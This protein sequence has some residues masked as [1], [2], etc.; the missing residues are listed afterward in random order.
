MKFKYLLLSLIFFISFAKAQ[1][2]ADFLINYPFPNCSPAVISFVNQ[3]TGAGLLSYEWNFGI[4]AGINSTQLNPSTTFIACGTYNVSLKTTNSSGQVSTTNKQVVINC[5]PKAN[6]SVISTTGCSPITVN[7][8]SVLCNPGNA[9]ITSYQW[10]F[11]DGFGSTSANPTHVYTGSGCKSVTLI[12]TNS[13]GCSDDTTITDIVC[14][15]PAPVADFTSTVPIG[16]ASPFNVTYTSTTSGV[17]PP[18][19]YQWSFQGG[20]PSTS[21]SANP[22]VIYNS[23]GVY[24]SQLIVTDATGCKDTIKKFNYVIISANA[25]DFTIDQTSICNPNSVFVQALNSQYATSLLWSCT[26]GTL[27]T[28]VDPENIVFFNTPGSYNLCLTMNFPGNCIATKCTTV[29]VKPSPIADFTSIGNIPTCQPPLN[30]TYTNTSTGTG[31]TYQW[32]FPGGNPSSSSQQTPPL[33]NYNS[34][35]NY[36]TKLIATNSVGC[37]DTLV[38]SALVNID[39]PVASF[40]PS[41]LLGC[42]PLDVTFNSTQST[43]SPTQ[44]FWNFGDS[45]N[46]NAVQSTLQNPSHTYTT[47]G[48]FNVRLII[49]NAQGC[50]DTLIF[51][52]IKTGT[53]PNANFVANPLVACVGVPISFTNQTTGLTPNSYFFWD[54]IQSPPFN[55]MSNLT[56]PVY[57]YNDTGWFDVTYIACSWGCCDTITKPDYIHI[58]APVAKISVDK[59]C[60][61]INNVTL[62]GENSLGADTYSWN[63][64]G[65]IPST[66]NSPTLNVNYPVSGIYT[67]T[68][69]VTNIQ[70]GCSHTSTKDINIKDVEADFYSVD[71]AECSP[72]NF[73][74]VNTSQDASSYKWTFLNSLNQVVATTVAVNPCINFVI[75]GVY[76][77]MLVATDVN[78]CKDTLKQNPLFINYGLNVSF[79]GN[80]ANACAPYLG[81][82]IGNVSSTSV[83]FPVSY[84]WDFG[85]PA[86]GSLN[87]A[88]S[89]NASHTFSSAGFFTITLSVTD[90]HG[91]VTSF[92]VPDYM[93]TYKPAADFI[94]VDTLICLSTP[95]CMIN[96]ASGQQPLSYNWNFGDGS[97][98]NTLQ[99]PCHQYSDTGSYSVSVIVTDAVGCKD[100][101]LKTLYQKV[102]SPQADFIADSTSADC[103]PLIVNFTNLSTSYDSTTTF[104]WN[105]GDGYTSNALNPFHIYNISGQFDVT[106]ILT[107]GDGCKDTIIY[108]D[109]INI[110][111]PN[112]VVS[113]SNVTGCP[114]FHVC[115]TAS[116]TNSLSYIWNYG[117]GT[118]LPGPDSVCY[119]YFTEGDFVPQV[120]LDDGAGC[121]YALSLDTIHAYTPTAAFVADKYFV[122]QN[123]TIQF[124]DTSSSEIQISSRL[125]DFGDPSSGSSNSSTILN[126]IH[127]YN[128]VGIYYVS[129]TVTNL[130]GCSSTITDTIVVT[131]L[132]VA[133]FVAN[134]P[135][136]CINSN[137]LFDNTTV[138]A[139]P[140]SS[141]LWNYG[142]PASGINNTSTLEDGFHIYNAA[143]TYTVKLT[144]TAITGCS[145]TVTSSVT[146][147]PSATANAGPDKT[148]CINNLTSL[149]ASGG[150]SYTWLPITSISPTN[151]AT[152][153]VNPTINTTYTVTVT[154]SNGCTASD[155]VIVSINTLPSINAGADITICPGVITQLNASGGVSYAWS[156]GSSLSNPNIANPTTNTTNNITYTVIGTDNNGC[157]AKDTINIT[158]YQSP[159]ANAGVDLEMCYTD[160]VTLQGIGGIAFN[161]SPAISVNNPTDSVTIANPLVTTTYILTVTDTNGCKDNDNIIVTVHQAPNINAGLDQTVCL[162]NVANLY[163]SGLVNYN[164]SP[165]PTLSSTTIPNPSAFTV[166]DNEYFLQGTDAFG[167]IGFDSVMVTV[168]QPF[169]MIVG[170][171]AEVCEGQSIQLSA[172]GAVS[173]QWEP[174]SS[175]DNP[176]VSQPYASPS[177]NTTYTVIGSDNICFQDVAYIEVIVHPLPIAYAGEDQIILSGETVILG[178]SGTGTYSWSPPDGL[179]CSDCTSPEAT[180]LE[181]TTYVLTVTNEF[182]CRIEDSVKIRVGCQDDV[183]FVPN[184]FSPNGDG[185]NDVFYVRSNGLRF[186]DYMRIYDR[187]GTVVFETTDKN[188]GWDGTYNNKDVLPGVY[189]YYL[190]A[191]CSNGQA[192]MKQGNITLIR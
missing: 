166:T 88:T 71:S 65:G 32:F 53:L 157:S 36:L 114:P 100:T 93:K 191:T 94:S 57:S 41:A 45:G 141:Y 29:V 6:F 115:Y 78:G 149:T 84:Q 15:I 98:N 85:D 142:D 79:N 8:S 23:A 112:A 123:G 156:P 173:Y 40:V 181:T 188:T 158:V 106:L 120:I 10:D 175:L 132:P 178:A 130:Y 92:T 189:V 145:D 21:N 11:G 81:Q 186:M 108:N 49:V 134:D 60:T 152:I 169:T 133:S 52:N 5:K 136:V 20:I 62:H 97:P 102:I 69:T 33:I 126:P 56:G 131:A 70:T 113:I 184:A 148:I 9:T 111:G 39:C 25:S 91:C 24:W 140:I 80:N 59:N 14:P 138:S 47:A 44:W 73:C 128:A 22:S 150:V 116:S 192:I 159:I 17:N 187:W 26:G 172:E 153:N 4:V 54:F 83:S 122:C 109:Y 13:N 27:A 180:P 174:A 74:F 117:D 31:N 34:C 3:S 125:W 160:S 185:F 82:F 171:G 18:F 77:V 75:P 129:L 37:I 162:G 110:N 155:V 103:P 163:A 64:P 135:T 46:P 96:Q 35:G 55:I 48:A 147:Y 151:T 30:V 101:A 179:S 58:L 1:V 139:A 67:V 89:L 95:A 16:C 104:L 38:D 66:S 161:W 105:F 146:I 63:I 19:T 176:Y 164:W 51:I 72:H 7:F 87:T 43:G 168:I 2:N 177:S 165:D 183:V 170:P 42:V 50:R 12:I 190:R 99:A 28:T 76:G 86:S 127:S 182:G 137:I 90:N 118:V 119:T 144:L 143:G 107:S 61:N 167:C 68:L 121:A 124:N 154:N